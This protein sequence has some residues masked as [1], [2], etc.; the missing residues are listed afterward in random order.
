MER[1]NSNPNQTQSKPTRF[2]GDAQAGGAQSTIIRIAEYGIRF[3]LGAVLANGTLLGGCIPFGLGFVGASDPGLSHLFS[4]L[5]CC[6]GYLFALSFSVSLKYIA[7]SI[8][9]FAVSFAFFDLRVY[10]KAWFMPLMTSFLTAAT[11]F[12]Y[13]PEQGF[14][15]R[16]VLL[17]IMEVSVAG[18]SA[19]FYKI[20]FSPWNTS[21]EEPLSRK[22]ITAILLFGISVFIALAQVHLPGQ[23]S[24][25]RLAAAFFVMF[26]AWKNGI[27]IGSAVG[28]A[29]GVAMDLAAGVAPFYAMAYGLSGLVAGVVSRKGRLLTAVTYVLVNGI[30]VLWALEYLSSLSILYEVFIAS[31]LFL[32]VPEQ[33]L[34]RLSVLFQAIPSAETE[35]ESPPIRSYIK[36]RLEEASAAFREL[37]E[38]IRSSFQ[39]N[40]TSDH[41]IA[42]LFDR[43]AGR[44]CRNCPLYASCWQ[45][46]Y[47]ATF[48]ALCSA[49][50]AMLERG[51]A[52]VS[53]F[54]TQFSKRCMRFPSFLAATN[55]ELTALLYRRQYR[56]RLMESRMAVCYQYEDLAGILD[57]TAAQLNAPLQTNPQYMRKVTQLLQEMELDAQCSVFYD[58]GNHL[59]IEIE[60]E[61]LSILG[62]DHMQTQLS[63]LL[64]VPLR[65]PQW[66]EGERERIVFTE[67]EP[68][69]AII[70]VAARRKEK[71]A[72]SGDN[73]SYFKTEDGI[74]YL[75]LADGMGSGEAAARESSLAIHLLE[76]F[77]KAGVHPEPALKTL[78]SA[79]ILR[80][81]SEGGFTT[82]DLLQVNLFTGQAD[83]YK[84]G[85]SPSYFC[86]KQRVRRIS[87]S[88]MPVGLSAGGIPAPDIAHFHVDA[89]DLVVLVSDGILGGREDQWLRNLTTD[90]PQ[91]SPPRKLA[92]RIIETS[93]KSI[94]CQDDKTV[95]VLAVE[96]RT[97]PTDGAIQSV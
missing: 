67:L 75:L 25:G 59:R 64:D 45:R 14:S 36:E 89:G 13:L 61:G 1:T 28:I 2:L 16:A 42:V 96:T 69:A 29:T 46:G 9:I 62:Q 37:Y 68:L 58:A 60:G 35:K 4:L 20:A 8:L 49:S 51:R 44:I 55:E 43:A 38:G 70:G 95:M 48:D 66:K 3:F 91:G 56:N 34:S 52:E 40:R 92:R 78:N 11:G 73:G 54:P 47:A 53:D 21:T 22:Q 80:S 19:Y 23:I 85:T 71:E 31:V 5:G 97:P 83:L 24:V 84:F 18:I 72:I 26:Y 82:L 65:P 77:L 15:A 87:G 39:S 27:G 7:A 63:D 79:L 6:I 81:D 88:T 32:L 10:R 76:R 93:E 50:K 74:L 86:Q 94:G 41:D 30:T 90:H 33:R 12:V 57:Q 17:F